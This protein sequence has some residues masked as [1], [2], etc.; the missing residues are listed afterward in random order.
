MEMNDQALKQ[1]EFR[2]ASVRTVM[3]K[4][5]PWWVAADV[6]AVLEIENVGN[7]ISRLEKD[8]VRQADT[9]RSNGRPYKMTVVSEPGLYELIIRSD[10]PQARPFRR[11]IT[12]EVLPEIRRTGRYS[13]DVS[14]WLSSDPSQWHK[15][16]PDAYFLQIFRLKGKRPP[17]DGNLKYTPWISHVNNDPIYKRL[18]VGIL[19]ALNLLNPLIGKY[20]APTS[21]DS[22]RSSAI[23]WRSS[24][25]S[26]ERLIVISGIPIRSLF[27]YFNSSSASNWPKASNSIRAR[28]VTCPYK[29]AFPFR[30]TLLEPKK[31]YHHWR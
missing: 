17:K 14:P 2:G 3:I 26:W 30:F 20:R 22:R 16:F 29:R 15:T 10:K 28:P 11:W 23:A 7:A 1:F 18:D 27:Y 6:C 12:K 5:E 13:K 21:G 25:S 24:Y 31:N 8:D 4:G 9:L 19:E